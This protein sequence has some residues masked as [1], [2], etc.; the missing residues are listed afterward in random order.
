MTEP[1][2]L[3]DRPYPEVVDDVLITV[4]GGVANEEHVFDERVAEYD[5]SQPVE[6]AR[7]VRSVTGIGSDGARRTFEQGTDYQLVPGGGAAP[8]RIRWL[9]DR[10]VRPQH[11]TTFLVDYWRADSRSPL[12]D[13]S[14][15]SV[16]RTLVEAISRELVVVYEQI[17]LAYLAGFIDWAEGTSLDFVVSIL[18]V[19]RRTADFAQGDVTFFRS[20]G[21]DS[22][23]IPAGTR[24]ATSAGDAV[25][26]T[27]SLRT[28]Q[29]GQSNVTVPVRATV[30]G[31]DGMVGAGG[32]TRLLVGIQGIDRVTNT[33]ATTTPAAAE[34]DDELRRRAKAKLQGLNQATVAAILRA[35]AEAGTEDFELHDPQW[36]PDTPHLW[37][38]PG[39]VELLIKDDPS[40]L[41][42]VVGAVEGARAAGVHVAVIARLVF[43][44]L[45]LQVRVAATV[46]PDGQQR[47][48]QNVLDALGA[49]VTRP[50]GQPVPGIDLRDA[51][52]VALEVEVGALTGEA[53]LRDVVV[54]AVDPANAEQPTARVPRRDLITRD[55]AP[56]TD[57]DIQ[58]WEF[59]IVTELAGG[60]AL[61]RLDMSD[62]DIDTVV[63]LTGTTGG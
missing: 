63:E 10:G 44:T 17:N 39:T 1:P 46:P 42:A 58:A 52:A 11:L 53:A 9:T 56:A 59:Q 47:I 15:G 3:V 61:P 13:I 30:P 35:A 20:T 16:T 62:A 25:F 28:L 12:T 18:D 34:T 2:R 6:S 32:I 7:G 23:T 22:I 24:V 40:R 4:V 51:I 38:E 14:V 54:F 31:A 21:S 48:K 60:A 55:G 49:A 36:P 19:Q 57:A 45:R 29:P 27:S 43:V 50:A 5:L 8:D 26:E 33:D 37:T 41:D